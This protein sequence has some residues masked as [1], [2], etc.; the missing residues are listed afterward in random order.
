ME[1]ALVELSVGRA[2]SDGL[3]AVA[4]DALALPLP[5]AAVAKSLAASSFPRSDSICCAAPFEPVGLV[6]SSTPAA[7]LVSPSGAAFWADVEA[8]GAEGMAIGTPNAA[9]RVCDSMASV[10]ALGSVS[11]L[12]SSSAD[13][14]LTTAAV[15]LE[16]ASEPP[17]FEA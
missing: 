6:A 5:W 11:A 4:S 8:G 10:S 3:F 7:G 17:E 2:S 9:A 1:L 15:V 16:E 12:L 13:L 14:S